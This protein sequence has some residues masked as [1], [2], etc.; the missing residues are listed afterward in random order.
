M[1]TK[2]LHLDPARR[3]LIGAFVDAYLRLSEEES[4]RFQRA[5]EEAQLLPSEEEEIVEY[6]TSWEEKG[7]EIGRKEGLQQGMQLGMQ[8]GA[9]RILRDLLLDVLTT[10]FGSVD[11]SV[12]DRIR[13]IDSNDELRRLHHQAL[14]AGA[15]GEL[16]L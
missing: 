11:T 10:R 8:Q 3:Y 7:R 12:V 13:A 15:I 1:N 4:R 5:L 2:A 9:V 14:T 6:V 16:G